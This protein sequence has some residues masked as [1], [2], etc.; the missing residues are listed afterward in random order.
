MS[1]EQNRT[2]DEKIS[3]YNKKQILA[4]LKQTNCNPNKT[5]VVDARYLHK[6]VKGTVDFMLKTAAISNHV[7]T[8]CVDFIDTRAKMNQEKITEVMA[9]NKR[10]SNVSKCVA[11]LSE[12]GAA[13]LTDNTL[14]ATLAAIAEFESHPETTEL[15]GIDLKRL[16]KYLAN[17]M[18][19]YPTEDLEEGPTKQFL[20]KCY[21]VCWIY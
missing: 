6:N 11:D 21:G 3:A 2:P 13:H 10:F 14:P 16:Y 8:N 12:S 20:Y 4:R 7:S 19:G 15:N 18:A 5:H 9:I 1:S 17:L